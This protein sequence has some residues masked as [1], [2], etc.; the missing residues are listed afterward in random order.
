MSAL[1]ISAVFTASILLCSSLEAQAFYWQRDSVATGAG[2]LGRSD[3]NGGGPGGAFTA[4]VVGSS[5]PLAGQTSAI[6]QFRFLTS[7]GSALPNSGSVGLNWINPYV[8]AA[9]DF[10][11]AGQSVTNLAAMNQVNVMSE[12][13]E[14]PWVA[15]AWGASNV[16]AAATHTLWSDIY[17]WGTPVQV[18]LKVLISW[19]GG[20]IGSG[21]GNPGF[22]TSWTNDVWTISGTVLQH[23]GGPQTVTIGSGQ[24]STENFTVSATNI[25]PNNGSLYLDIEWAAQV[26]DTVTWQGGHTHGFRAQNLGDPDPFTPDR[27]SGLA[28]STVLIEM[29]L[30]NEP[31]PLGTGGE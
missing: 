18:V 29:V 10:N 8:N 26:G 13:W 5:V 14:V 17:P 16:T 23:A 28:Q 25:D 21:Q 3:V 24:I 30:D 4:G 6:S 12:L 2:S 1:K 15:N 22:F 9:I 11:P 27:L 31:S 7:V 20:A 19:Q